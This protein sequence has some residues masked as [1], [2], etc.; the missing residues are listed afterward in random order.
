MSHHHTYYVTAATNPSKFKAEQ[1]ISFWNWTIF[2]FVQKHWLQVQMHE[3]EQEI[4]QETASALRKS[5]DK[6]T[7]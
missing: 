2:F 3:L 6:V 7:V 1:G 4:L 5:E